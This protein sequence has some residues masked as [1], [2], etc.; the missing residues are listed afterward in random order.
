MPGLDFKAMVSCLSNDYAGELGAPKI[1][2]TDDARLICKS[3]V[4]GYS[5]KLKKWSTCPHALLPQNFRQLTPHS[6][7]LRRLRQ[8]N[9]MERQRFRQ[10]R[11]SLRHQGPPNV[12]RRVPSREQELL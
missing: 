7:L 8:R 3:T 4:P 12:L 1:Q 2:L 6:A 5:L 11:P 9:S 10:T